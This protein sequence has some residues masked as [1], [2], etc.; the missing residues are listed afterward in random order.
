[1]LVEASEFQPRSSNDRASPLATR[2]LETPFFRGL[3]GAEAV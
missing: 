1:M 3:S 2:D